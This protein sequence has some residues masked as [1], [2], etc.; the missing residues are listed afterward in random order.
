MKI[1]KTVAV[2]LLLLFV[3]NSAFIFMFYELDLRYKTLN[4]FK[5]TT[6][7]F[8]S[9]S[10]KIEFSSIQVFAEKGFT[11]TLNSKL[12]DIEIDFKAKVYSIGEY[13]NIFQTADRNQG[14]RIEISKPGTL[15]LVIGD[16]KI[17]AVVLTDSLK[18]DKWYEISIKIDK[19]GKLDV[20]ID[21]IKVASLFLDPIDY[22]LDSVAVGTGMSKSRPFDG[23]IENF[24][25]QGK[26]FI[27]QRGVILYTFYLANLLECFFIL[28]F[29]IF[30]VA[31]FKKFTFDDDVV[32]FI[33]AVAIC[34]WCLSLTL[35]GVFLAYTFQISKWVPHVLFLI[36]TLML[37]CCPAFIRKN[38]YPLGAIVLAATLA[39]L[40]SI[41]PVFKAYPFAVIAL[42]FFGVSA[43][44]YLSMKSL[45]NNGFSNFSKKFFALVLI[46]VVGA[47]AWFSL[48]DLPNWTEYVDSQKRSWVTSLLGFVALTIALTFV[49]KRKIHSF[50]LV[51]P[52]HAQDKINKYLPVFHTVALSV[53]SWMSFRFDTLF[54]GSSST[55]WE[56]YVGPIRT[57]RSGGWLL[58]DVPSQYGF[59]NILLASLVPSASSWQSFYVFQGALLFI[60]SSSCYL[61]AIRFARVSLLDKLI[62]FLIILVGVFF[63]DPTLIG[64]SLYPSSSVVR[65]FWCYVLILYLLI[66]P[67]FNYKQFF[68][69]AACWVVS[70]WWSA[71]SAIYTS[72]ILFMAVL[73]RLELSKNLHNETRIMGA[74]LRYSLIAFSI[75]GLVSIFIFVYYKRHIGTFPD[76][77]SYV[78]HAFGYAS[79]F[80]STQIKWNGPI[81]FLALMFLG[82]LLLYMGIYRVNKTNKTL[83]PIAGMMGCLWAISTY[84][85]GRAVP[86]NVTAIL[87]ILG[88]MSYFAI[89]ASRKEPLSHYGTVLKLSALPLMF[90]LVMPGLTPKFLATLHHSESFSNDITNQMNNSDDE[91]VQLMSEAKI[92]SETP[93]TYYGNTGAMPLVSMAGKRFVSENTWLPSPLQ[94][95]EEPISS[96]RRFLYM[97]RFIHRNYREGYL[98]QQNANSPD[99]FENWLEILNKFYT[100][101][102]VYR[103]KEYTIWHFKPR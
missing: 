73:A 13:N 78:E 31:K 20:L 35:I 81:V 15:G 6:L 72:S 48:F 28:V 38:R 65:F 94:L 55:H 36:S 53:F 79:G 56:Y 41:V 85:I 83:V 92:T 44:V 75:L 100:A 25:I 21:S 18:L 70:V 71:E 16:E 67:Q 46:G 61:V 84:Y 32:D 49:Y 50:G 33:E 40:I 17:T 7:N 74:L 88:V 66:F 103:G 42:I 5:S 12:K 29:S 39:M 52:K 57:I 9:R 102:K 96:E 64:P 1:K 77:Y 10:Q 54:L 93:V 95:L 87:P 89:L 101:D 45:G 27:K 97:E 26:S 51:F 47:I 19:F 30:A 23:K 86:N 59:L 8:D 37:V 22:K 82:L 63:A 58:W 14:I 69:A 91:L 4:T 60:V 80:G 99:R 76:V 2:I 68:F 98:I 34:G 24:R 3:I 11:E 62:A 43:S 90:L